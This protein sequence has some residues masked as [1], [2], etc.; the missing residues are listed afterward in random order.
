MAKI[1]IKLKKMYLWLLL[2]I[3]FY[4]LLGL[5]FLFWKE[6]DLKFSLLNSRFTVVLFLVIAALFD[7]VLPLWQ[8]ISFFSM[9]KKRNKEIKIN[10]YLKYQKMLL[11]YAFLGGYLS[12]LAY[13]ISIPK[14]PLLI[15]IMAGIYSLY[16]YYPSSK[17]INFD[18]KIF[19]L[20]FTDEKNE[21]NN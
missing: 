20:K 7:F 3:I 19:N 8:K 5:Y 18:K 21:K 16:F 11:G 9:V 12:I 15:I 4:L 6:F 17:K 1:V 2:P 14:I 10:T 13:I